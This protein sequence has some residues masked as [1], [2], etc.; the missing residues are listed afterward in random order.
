[1]EALIV[2]YDNRLNLSTKSRIVHERNAIFKISFFQLMSL[3]KHT[4]VR[5]DSVRLNKNKKYY[6]E[7][8][9]LRIFYSMSI[10]SL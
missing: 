7:C 8:V 1:M 6:L 4:S 9:G 10:E 2:L 3:F 5:I